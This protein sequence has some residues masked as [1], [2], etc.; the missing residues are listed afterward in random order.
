MLLIKLATCR[1]VDGSNTVSVQLRT[2]CS[3]GVASGGLRHLKRGCQVN[4]CSVQRVGIVCNRQKITSC[5]FKASIHY[6]TSTI[7]DSKNYSIATCLRVRLFKEAEF[8][9]VFR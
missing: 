6:L 9:E 8:A 2:K 7:R 5:K 3:V 1:S 4:T